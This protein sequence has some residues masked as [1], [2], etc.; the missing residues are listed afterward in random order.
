MTQ[1]KKALLLTVVLV[2]VAACRDHERALTQSYGDG[3]VSGQVVVGSSMINRDPAGI[4]VMVRGTGMTLTLA[5]EGR[6][7]FFGVP[8]QSEL[9]FRRQS[10]GINASLSL[11]RQNG[12]LVIEVDSNGARPG[13]RRGVA[14]L[15]PLLQYEGLIKS[16]ATD[17]LVVADSHGQDVTFKLTDKTVIRKGNDSLTAAD[18]EENDRVHVTAYQ[19]D[20]DTIAVEVKLQNEDAGDGDNGSQ[21]PTATA[22]GLVATKGASDMVVHRSNGKDVTVQ[23]DDSTKIKKYGQPIA[24]ADINEGDH[25]ECRGT[26]VDSSTIKAVQINVENA[27][28]SGGN[29]RR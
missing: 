15:P 23:V 1:T 25:V 6:F 7:T 4:Q 5:S 2:L 13:R 11:G 10:D 26:S 20:G 3:V 9:Q 24:F 22:N 28:G 29:G 17:T 8:E 16:V 19:K 21:T 27:P 12:S 18:L 14:P